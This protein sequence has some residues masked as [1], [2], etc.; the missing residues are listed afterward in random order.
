MTDSSSKVAN[1]MAKIDGRFELGIAPYLK[2]NDASASGA[3]ASGSCLVMF[4]HG[5]ARKEAAWAFVQY[6]TSASV[7]ADFAAGTG[8]LPANK[9]AQESETWQALIAEYPVYQVGLNQLLET[10]DTMRSVTVGPSADFYYGIIND[11]SDML[12]SDLSVEETVDLMANDL[13]GMLAQYAK[14]NP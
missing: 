5:D 6:L 7:Q 4:D 9:E 1:M 2:V 13:G 12:E 14:A 8:Y 3:T 11:I 10:P